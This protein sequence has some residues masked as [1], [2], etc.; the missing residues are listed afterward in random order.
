MNQR[1]ESISIGVLEQ[2]CESY[3][4]RRRPRSEHTNNGYIFIRDEMEGQTN[5]IHVHNGDGRRRVQEREPDRSRS[6]KRPVELVAFWLETFTV[7]E[8]STFYAFSYKNRS[9]YST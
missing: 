5:L 4:W 2:R 8:Q 6:P 9:Q 7:V 1:V 3:S